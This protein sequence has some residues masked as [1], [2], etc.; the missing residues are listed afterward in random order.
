MQVD[1]NVSESDVGN[2]HV[3]Q[4]VDF[5]VDAYTDRTFKGA[6]TQVR[7]APITVQNV[8]TYDVVVGVPNPELLLMPGMTANITI[9]L[10][11][12][13]DVLR[14]PVRATAFTPRHFFSFGSHSHQH[15]QRGP[16]V[17]IL[18]DDGRLR[19]VRVMLGLNDGNNVE[20]LRGD[21]KPGD[22]VVLDQIGG[23]HAGGAMAG[24]GM[25]MPHL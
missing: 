23:T 17:W 24:P 9:L 1:A 14:V 11:R 12:R 6:V 3:G 15:S 19:P 22:E 18:T 20:I 25:H 8:V 7:Q 5:T 10:D 16:R 4:G 21:L 13:E 2:V